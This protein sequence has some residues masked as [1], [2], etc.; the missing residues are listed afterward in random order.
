[1]S[2]DSYQILANIWWVG[3]IAYSGHPGVGVVM[4]LWGTALLIYGKKINENR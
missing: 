4:W 2:G 3:A 1:M